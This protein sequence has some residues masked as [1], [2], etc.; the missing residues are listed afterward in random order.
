MAE[1]TDRFIK[2]QKNITPVPRDYVERYI[3]A[4]DV[5][6]WASDKELTDFAYEV[7]ATEFP[8]IVLDRQSKD[9]TSF[10]IQVKSDIQDFII[11]LGKLL[12]T[13]Q[14]K[15]QIIYRDDPE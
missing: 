15:V 14:P 6:V 13:K 5:F 3:R 7:V 11:S 4:G 8:G 10:E 2:I 1:N 9:S 12:E